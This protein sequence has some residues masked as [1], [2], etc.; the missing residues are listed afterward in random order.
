VEGVPP[1]A[2]LVTGHRELGFSLPTAE[3]ARLVAE[4]LPGY[5]RERSTWLAALGVQSD[6]GGS[7]PVASLAEAKARY[8]AR[9]LSR[10]AALVNA[11]R[12]AAE[13]DVAAAV[14]ALQAAGS[15]EEIAAL[16]IPEAKQL[17]I[18]Q[19]QVTAELGRARRTAPT[20]SGP[21]ALLRFASPCLVHGLV[22]V[23][24]AR[25]LRDFVVMAANVGYLPGRVSFAVRSHR[26]LDLVTFLRGIEL[27][28]GA[29]EESAHGHLAATGGSL[30]CASFNR[31]L[32]ALG[33]GPEAMVPVEPA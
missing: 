15:P 12:R 17:D 2:V 18:Y 8:G 14:R 9:T 22:A 29:D 31:M 26:R 16:A 30:G 3:L 10:A 25:R 23:S 28:R 7:A 4:G 27:E 33:F 6:A 19:Q 32:A 5:E 20:F 13:H 1:G 21:V 11:P 24:W